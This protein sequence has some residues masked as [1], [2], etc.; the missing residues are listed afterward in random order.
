MQI[1]VDGHIATVVVTSERDPY[2]TGDSPEQYY[3]EILEVVN[4]EGEVVEPSARL[5]ELIEDEA[6]GTYIYG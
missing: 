4:E 1:E 3:V 5:E 2:G 6:I